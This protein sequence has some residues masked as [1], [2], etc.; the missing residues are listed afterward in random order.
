MQIELSDDQNANI[1][2]DS[3]GCILMQMLQINTLY[4]PLLSSFI[5]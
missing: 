4:F 2:T 3:K 5:F 1:I